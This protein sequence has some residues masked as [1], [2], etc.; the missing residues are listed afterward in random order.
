MKNVGSRLMKGT[1][2]LAPLG[3]LEEEFA[4]EKWDAD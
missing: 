3:Q 2:A 1:A 4:K